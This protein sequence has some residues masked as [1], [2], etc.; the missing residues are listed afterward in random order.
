VNE[1]IILQLRNLD[2]EIRR[3]HSLASNPEMFGYHVQYWS[4]VEALQNVRKMH[5]LPPLKLKK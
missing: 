1:Q 2:K 3:C 5:G 4:K